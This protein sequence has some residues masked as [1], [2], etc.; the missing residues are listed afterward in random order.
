MRISAV[1]ILTFFF[2]L[3][4]AAKELPPGDFTDKACVACHEKETA[5]LVGEWRAGVHASSGVKCIACHGNRHDGAAARARKNDACIAC[6]GGPKDPVVRSYVT[7][8]HGVIA[9]IEGR[10]WDWSKPLEDANIRAPSCAY[11]HLNAGRHGVRKS[12]PSGAEKSR[13][14]M[15]EALEE[16]CLDC[17]SPRY[18]AVLFAAGERGLEIGR[19]K[20]RE[21]EALLESLAPPPPLPATEPEAARELRRRVAIMR[22]QSLKSL[23][24]GLAHHSPDFQWW[25]GQAALDGDL[26]RVKAALSRLR[27]QKNLAG[28]SAGGSD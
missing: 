15:R 1:V 26:L 24:L 19:M 28:G 18:V 9:A 8:K 13:E 6:H 12:G 11:C 3:A 4:A 5:D 2:A 22:D 10:Q 20:V 23:R 17:H 27:R 21:A 25:Y 7:S 14:A 16:A